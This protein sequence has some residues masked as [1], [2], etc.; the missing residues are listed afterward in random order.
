MLD[1]FSG[2]AWFSTLN[3]KLRYWQVEM[4]DSDKEKT[5]FTSGLGLWQFR[6]MPMRLCNAVATLE[7]LIEQVFVGMSWQ[8]C[9]RLSQ[10]HNCVRKIVRRRSAPPLRSLR[11]SGGKR[12]TQF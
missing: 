10:R 9:S 11:M 2:A 7:R 8:C 1:A 6:V 3:L 4:K 12:Q 5:A